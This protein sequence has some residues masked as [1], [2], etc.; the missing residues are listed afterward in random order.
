MTAAKAADA[1]RRPGRPAH[2]RTAPLAKSMPVKRSLT[3][4]QR[5]VTLTVL[6]AVAIVIGVEVIARDYADL[7]Q[8]VSVP[9]TSTDTYFVVRRPSA[10]RTVVVPTLLA[11][12]WGVAGIYLFRRERDRPR[13]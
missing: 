5:V 6:A 9:A 12:A 7:A 10:V 13:T 1:V 4:G 8:A 11:L 2:G 3:I